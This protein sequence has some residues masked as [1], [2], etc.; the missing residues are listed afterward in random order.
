MT[1]N[2]ERENL[3]NY[4]ENNSQ[5]LSLAKEKFHFYKIVHRIN[6]ISCLYLKTKN[7]VFNFFELVTNHI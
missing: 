1:E 2:H 4:E 5:R 7:Y 6:S 3:Y